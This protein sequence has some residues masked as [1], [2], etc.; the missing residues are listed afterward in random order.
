MNI[1]NVVLKILS[2]SGSAWIRIHFEN[3]IRIRIHLKS[4]ARI[5][6]K[7]MR[8]RKPAWHALHVIREN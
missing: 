5:R 2:G 6:I 7:S 4:W 3:W 1:K 8:I